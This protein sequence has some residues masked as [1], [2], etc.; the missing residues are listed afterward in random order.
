MVNFCKMIIGVCGRVSAGKETLTSFLRDKGFVYLETSAIIKEELAKL[1][2]EITRENMQNWA[3]DLR[4]KNGVG[5]LMKL[6]LERVKKEPKKN[7]LFDSLRNTGEASFLEK[8]IKD[9]ILIG[10][11]AP[12]KIRFQRMLARGKSS[13]PK[14]W[15]EFLKMDARDNFDAS[16]PMGQQTGRLLERADFVIVN[17]KDLQDAMKRVEEV[18]GHIEKKN[19]L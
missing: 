19:S 18:W 16:N 3:D 7:Y 15:D 4:K 14:T 13:D 1:G 17:D 9:F 11:D 5:A 10:V 2:L 6:M 8:K 12:Q